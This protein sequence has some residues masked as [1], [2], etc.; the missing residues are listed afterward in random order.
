MKV[1]IQGPAQSLA[2]L[3]SH[4]IQQLKPVLE[5][6]PQYQDE[7]AWDAWYS[8]QEET[9]SP[10]YLIIRLRF[11]SQAM[12]GD[13]TPAL[14]GTLGKLVLLG[15]LNE[16]LYS[17]LTLQQA[18]PAGA[19]T[20][21]DLPGFLESSTWE[22]AGATGQEAATHLQPLVDA[23]IRLVQVPDRPGLVTP[24]VVCRIINEAYYMLGEGSATREAIDSAMRLGVNYPKGPLAWGDEL[25]LENVVAVLESLQ[26]YAGN[27]AYRIAPALLAAAHQKM[28][29]N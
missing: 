24:R 8:A 22:I 7:D 13:A 19:F 28:L 23:G 2:R 11:V 5:A 26:R 16:P 25:G 15:L 10:F 12:G 18:Q 1:L 14:H 6:Y 4:P 27:D 21:N 20:F 3:A 9:C 29:A 17:Y